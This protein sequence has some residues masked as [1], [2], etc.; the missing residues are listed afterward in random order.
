MS[1]FG[2]YNSGNVKTS[3]NG[4]DW[5]YYSGIDRHDSVV[6]SPELK[7]FVAVANNNQSVSV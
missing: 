4:Y 7:L 1:L 6:W 2:V 3:Q 5:T